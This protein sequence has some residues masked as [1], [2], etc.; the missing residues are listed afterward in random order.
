MSETVNPV[1]LSLLVCD[2]VSRDLVTRKDSVMGVFSMITSAEL[3]VMLPSAAVFFQITDVHNV[4]EFEIRITD[5][6]GEREPVFS[7]GPVRC[8][9][10]SPLD[11]ITGT[12]GIRN[13]AFAHSGEYRVQ[14]WSQS[15]ILSEARFV[16]KAQPAEPREFGGFDRF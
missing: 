8:S 4:C 11:V 7:S 9:S 15:A 2:T 10:P 3:P 14:F 1:V 5:V 13:L 12:V 16:V 6:S